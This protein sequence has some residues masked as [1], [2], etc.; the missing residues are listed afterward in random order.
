[1]PDSPHVDSQERSLRPHNP[2]I[3]PPLPARISKTVSSILSCPKT[4]ILTKRVEW[5]EA[6]KFRRAEVSEPI[7]A[8]LETLE[9]QALAISA[10]ALKQWGECMYRRAK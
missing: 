7:E 9:Q 1:M 8:R 2:T 6:N 4:T 5:L 10:T 3:S